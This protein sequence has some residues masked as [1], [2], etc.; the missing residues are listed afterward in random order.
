MATRFY[1]RLLLATV[2]D[3]PSKSI[4]LAG[5][6]LGALWMAAFLSHAPSFP[7]TNV[8]V[9]QYLSQVIAYGALPSF[10]LLILLRA[11]HLRPDGSAV[12][13]SPLRTVQSA[14]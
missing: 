11:H 8:A 13:L 1:T 9:H 14:E 5:W 12:R 4:I 3:I 2:G 10:V 7:A 6:S